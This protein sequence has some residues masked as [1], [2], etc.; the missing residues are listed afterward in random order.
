MHRRELRLAV[1]F[2]ILAPA[3]MALG[4]EKAATEI[5][6]LEEMVVTATGTEVP[7]KETATSTTVYL[8]PEMDLRQEPRVSSFLRDVPGATLSQTGS[9]GGTTSLLLRGGN[10]NMT[11]VLLNGFRL[12]ETGGLFD[13]SKLTLDN[14]ERL[15]VVRGP[16]SSLYGNDAMTGVV[17]LFTR[18]GS[19]PPRLTAASLWGAHA[20]GHSRNNLISEQRL[21]LMGSAGAFSYSL[22][23]GRY[24]DTGILAFNNRFGSNV[25][26][27]RFD[28]EPL[29]NLTFTLTQYYVDTYYGFPTFSGD[30]FDP[31]EKGGLGLDPDQNQK[32]R[33]L[34]VGLTTRCTPFP[35]WEHELQLGFLNTLLRY[36][37]PANPKEVL[38]QDFDFFSR[39]QETQ[40]TAH[41]RT[42]LVFGAKERLAGTTTLGVE[43]RQARYEGWSRDWDWLTF[44]GYKESTTTA[45]RGSVTWYLQEQ[46]AVRERFFLNLGASLEDN[47]AFQKLEFCPRASAALRFPE[48]D[49]TLR[50]AGGRAVKAPSFL[51]TNSLNP[52]FRGNPK[53]NPEKNVS[54][55]VGAD[56]WLWQGRLRAGLT[57]FENH[58]T[59]L[60]QYVQTGFTTGT[61][62]NIAAARTKGIE[63]YV[64]TKPYR[65]LTLRASYTYLTQFKV[66][67]DGGITSINIITGKNLL[68]RP[69]QTVSFDLSYVRG[70]LE[71]NFRGLYV[72]VREDRRPS[73]LPP[74]F[75]A[76]ERRGGYFTADLAA[77]YTLVQNWHQVKSLKLTAR[78]L[79]LFDRDYEE[80]LGFSSP[81]F[82]IL[83]GLRL[84]I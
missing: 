36:N 9:R 32:S 18:K 70:P 27:A 80:V 66:L 19:G 45:H 63:A 65:G 48:T 28:L 56:Q 57:Y 77:S 60:I 31:K 30:R 24:D 58:F 81:R 16:M 55:E 40:W 73:S 34:L 11:L 15:E 67:D 59:D 78:A 51:E 72:G 1:F 76:R 3:A 62:E 69:R 35:W 21:S 71:L 4:A 10:N 82:Q 23:Y 42:N 46:L 14:V 2:L 64:Q 7:G 75:A 49:T 61:F 38:F 12:N 26:N 41:Y 5:Q 44:S 53:L 83:G 47:R 22:A 84:E 39:D 17:Q 6:T 50:A 25:V 52:F 20:E 33:L 43:L 37:N 79:N 74:Y 29:K 54:W 13:F 68:R 8:A